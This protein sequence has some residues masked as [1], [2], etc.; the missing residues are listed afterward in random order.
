M[1]VDKRKLPKEPNNKIMK[2]KPQ[3]KKR[4]EF[5]NLNLECYANNICSKGNIEYG[6]LAENTAGLNAL[7]L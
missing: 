3:I 2:Y 5:W 6:A 7:E 4:S 1:A